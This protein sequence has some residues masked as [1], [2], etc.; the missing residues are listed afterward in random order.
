MW[1]KYLSSQIFYLKKKKTLK[2]Q[3]YLRNKL[4]FICLSSQ[5]V[6]LGPNYVKKK[7]IAY[8]GVNAVSTC[9]GRLSL[10]AYP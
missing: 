9:A 10:A 2:K 1:N 6:L 7:Y 4:V 3:N 8:T 5:Q